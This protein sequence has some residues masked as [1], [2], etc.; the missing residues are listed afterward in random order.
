VIDYSSPNV[1]KELHVGHLRSTNIGDS[2]AR[3]LEF[4][5]H[6]VIRQNHIGD[7]GTPFG[8]LIEQ[9]V[10]VGEEQAQQALAVGEL[11][12]FYRAARKRF[13]TEPG[14][15]DRARQRVVLLQAGDPQTRAWWRSLLDQSLRYMQEVYRALGVTLT[16]ADVCAESFYNDRLAPL[17][18]E[19][20]ASGQAT[21]SDGAS[22]VFVPGFQNREGGPLP[23]IVRKRG[24]GFGYAAT[25][26]AAIRYRFREL[27]A[28]RAIY[29]VGSPQTQ[30]L[31]MIHAAAQQLGWLAPPARAEH[32]GFGSVL[33]NDG[34]MLA[35]R[36]GQS[37]RLVDLIHE[38]V[39]RADAQI[40]SLTARRAEAGREGPE[41]S[42]EQ[43]R[44]VA[45]MVGIGAIKY[46]DLSSDRIKDYVYEVARM[47]RFEGDTAGYLQ[48]T[49]ARVRGIFRK[50]Q[51]V[52]G[53]AVNIVEPTERSLALRLLAF[54]GTV[55]D[56]ERTLEPHRLAGY[57]YDVATAFT[58]FYDACPIL[59]ADPAVR[60]SRLVLADLTGRTI[61]CGLDV[62]GIE[63]PDV[64]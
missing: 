56:V 14:F 3:T 12:T 47:V 46:A 34:Q 26:L 58:K 52:A 10:D 33:G 6:T 41:M 48:Y 15:A 19:L 17:A 22:C 30:H 23:I 61:R 39:A 49:H 16:P 60:A 24:G 54:G 62:L 38:A 27:G 50:A 53:G 7:W 4:R 29:V 1:A 55:A 44:E 40:E 36:D 2:I 9:L 31:A 51:D 13:D 59:T 18:D 42:P 11:T 64:M 35:T 21:I 57:L 25:D 63:A 20:E 37:V 5:G 43:R 28:T 32:V 45:R 8:M